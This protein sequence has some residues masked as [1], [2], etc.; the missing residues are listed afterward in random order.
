MAVC[1]VLGV[2]VGVLGLLFLAAIAARIPSAAVGGGPQPA[3]F[4]GPRIAG[5]YNLSGCC[6]SVRG[7]SP[8]WCGLTRWRVCTGA[9]PRRGWSC[10]RR[11]GSARE[12]VRVSDGPIRI[13][14]L[15]SVRGTGGG[16]EKTILQG[17]AQTDP[18]RFVVTVCY[19][20]DRRDTIFAL[21]ELASQ[22]GVD[23]LEITERHSFDPAIWRA[24]RRLVRDRRID[25]VHGHE[26]KTDLLALLLA[27]AER[28]IPLAT[29]HGW[30]GRSTR[31]HLL[32]YPADRWLLRHFPRVIAVSEQIR[33]TLVEAG[34]RPHRVTTVLN[35]IDPTVFAR[36]PGLGATVRAELRIPSTA[37]VLGSV[38]RLEPQKRFD[39]LI[40][41]FDEVRRTC[42]NLTLIIAGDGSQR[43]ALADLLKRRGLESSCLLVGHRP[44]V[45]AVLH[46]LNLF[47][48]SSDYEGTPNAVLEAMAVE[49]PVVATRAGGTDQLIEHGVH[50][51]LV[52]PGR[53]DLLA[54]AIAEALGNRVAMAAWVR[55]AR[56]RIELELSFDARMHAVERICEQLVERPSKP[57]RSAMVVA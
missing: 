26:Y 6:G 13:L 52:L 43:A 33:H 3:L 7:A 11:I 47:V 8:I 45:V 40:E 49:T 48:Q 28:V 53:Y 31:E 42:P 23:Y 15:R 21:G 27:R 2:A 34:C 29:A 57:D 24:L 41:A 10:E 32:Y 44:D 20:R 39:L 56:R 54:E 5:V 22:L 50:G 35:G 18:K 4:E 19:I 30:T 36:Q 55:A 46:A 38:G 1:H 12:R 9:P 25:I 14:E 16:P 37:T 17:A 51:L